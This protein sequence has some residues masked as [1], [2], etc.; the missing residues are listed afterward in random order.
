MV[1]LVPLPPKTILALGSKVRSDDVALTLR[2]AAGGSVS[3]TVNGIG[4]VDKFLL[5]VWSR[6]AEMIGGSLTAFTVSTKLLLAVS[7]P[8]LTVIE[9]VAVPVWLSSGTTCTVRLLLLPPRRMLL[10]GASP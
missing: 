1:R 5:I 10:M 4:E 7:V 6:I 9:M 8:S 2:L 3:V